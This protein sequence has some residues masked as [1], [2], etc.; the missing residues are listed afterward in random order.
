[1]LK[2]ELKIL[3]DIGYRRDREWMILLDYVNGE[4]LDDDTLLENL[5]KNPCYIEIGAKHQF[6]PRFRLEPEMAKSWTAYRDVCL[7]WICNDVPES[8]CIYTKKAYINF[9]NAVADTMGRPVRKCHWKLNPQT[10]EALK[11]NTEPDYSPPMFKLIAK[12]L[13]FGNGKKKFIF[14]NFFLN[15]LDQKYNSHCN[16]PRLQKRDIEDVDV[17]RLAI[18]WP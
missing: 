10:H 4:M 17:S 7:D 6:H 18:G 9:Y 12:D 1:M 11:V 2:D 15:I 3:V 8:Q 16:T 5:V 13:K 14:E